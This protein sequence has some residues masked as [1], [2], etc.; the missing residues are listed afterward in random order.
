MNDLSMDPVRGQVLRVSS[1]KCREFVKCDST[2]L[3]QIKSSQALMHWFQKNYCTSSAT[4]VLL[5]TGYQYFL[6][7]ISR[8]VPLHWLEGWG[9]GLRVCGFSVVDRSTVICFRLIF[10][11]L[12]A[13][14][15]FPSS[16]TS[17]SIYTLHTLAGLS[18]LN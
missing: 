11:L 4:H 2:K 16:H 8:T 6:P 17:L 7:V 1:E 12:L 9:L 10:L 15:V 3:M 14:H 13:C 5:E 18:E